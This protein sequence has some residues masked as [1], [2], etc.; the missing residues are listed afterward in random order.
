M[1]SH[2]SCLHLYVLCRSHL[3]HFSALFTALQSGSVSLNSTKLFLGQGLCHSLSFGSS[4]QSD[5]SQIIPPQRDQFNQ[6]ISIQ[7][8]SIGTFS[9]DSLIS[10]IISGTSFVFQYCHFIL[11]YFLPPL[12]HCKPHDSG[13]FAYTTSEAQTLK[14][15]WHTIEI[16]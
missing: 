8:L 12:A 15:A 11:F 3:T 4:G 5:Y 2:H 13:D 10:S 7:S 1:A 9:S 6:K 14:I 16:Q